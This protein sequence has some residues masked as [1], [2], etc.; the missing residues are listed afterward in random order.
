AAAQ[1]QL[2]PGGGLRSGLRSPLGSHRMSRS[3]IV[4]GGVNRHTRFAGGSLDLLL[5]HG[6][7]GS[8]I[9]DRTTDPST[10]AA[11]A[12]PAERRTERFLA[13]ITANA[14][15]L[16]RQGWAVVTT[17]DAEGARLEAL[18]RELVAVRAEEQRAEVLAIRVP[19][20][21]DSAAA[22]DWKATV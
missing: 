9:L 10:A 3:P 13:D 1:E 5:A 7:D 8:P 14:D 20:G 2:D 16:D 18:V 12:N 21:M 6:D 4:A 15:E 22:S 11:A 19:P 17:A